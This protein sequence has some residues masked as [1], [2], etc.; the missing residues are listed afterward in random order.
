MQIYPGDKVR[1]IKSPYEYSIKNGT[2]AEIE[3][4]RY[5][6]FG[7]NQHL[8]ITKGLRCNLFRKHEIELYQEHSE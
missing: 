2:I 5:H 8:Y 1:I 7:K 3:T 6:H 4:I